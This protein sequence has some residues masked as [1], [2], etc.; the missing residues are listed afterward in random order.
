MIDVVNKYIVS[1]RSVPEWLPEFLDQII[2]I[3]NEEGQFSQPVFQ[4][5]NIV[6]I[7]ADNNNREEIMKIILMI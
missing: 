6:L 3:I 7:Y 4:I 5:L 1:S 2:V